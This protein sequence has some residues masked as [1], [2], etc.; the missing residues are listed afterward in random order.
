MPSNA[1]SIYFVSCS[2][3][4]AIFEAPHPLGRCINPDSTECATVPTICLWLSYDFDR[5]LRGVEF[6][7]VTFRYVAEQVV[8]RSSQPHG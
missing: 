8:F 6:R 3:N 1:M 4:S 5:T 7:D 2:P